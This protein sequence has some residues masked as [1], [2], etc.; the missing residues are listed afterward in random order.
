[1]LI[2]SDTSGTLERGELGFVILNENSN[3]L[4]LEDAFAVSSNKE[5][6]LITN[7]PFSFCQLKA[8]SSSRDPS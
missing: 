2:D 6:A 5:N 7:C 1:M 3:M 4:K 8:D